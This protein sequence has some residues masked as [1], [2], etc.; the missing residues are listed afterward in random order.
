VLQEVFRHGL[1]CRRSTTYRENLLSNIAS[2]SVQRCGDVKM[3][4][5]VCKLLRSRGI[6][7]SAVI[8][9]FRIFH[10]VRSTEYDDFAAGGATSPTANERK[11]PFSS[12]LRE[13]LPVVAVDSACDVDDGDIL[14][15]AI[16]GEI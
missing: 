14:A 4:D 16:W 15:G 11:G 5:A 1:N 6:G 7:P 10:K 3:V 2:L 12:P 13:P 8:R 9:P